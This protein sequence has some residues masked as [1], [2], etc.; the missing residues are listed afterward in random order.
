MELRCFNLE[1]DDEATDLRGLVSQGHN[2]LRSD[3]DAEPLEAGF[4]APGKPL[5]WRSEGLELP[6]SLVDPRISSLWTDYMTGEADTTG[7]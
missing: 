4:R 6:P 3:E 7:S 2:G 1:C 5:Y